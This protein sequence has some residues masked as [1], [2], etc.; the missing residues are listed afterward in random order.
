MCLKTNE[1][2]DS[3]HIDFF[4]SS[5][6]VRLE[7]Y[8]EMQELK[9]GLNSADHTVSGA[10]RPCI[11][12]QDN[13]YTIHVFLCFTTFTQNVRCGHHLSRL[14]ATVLILKLGES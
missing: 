13:K 4:W 10:C 6:R 2:V 11:S 1:K 5:F 12:F 7:L 9:L 3:M 14:V 8:G